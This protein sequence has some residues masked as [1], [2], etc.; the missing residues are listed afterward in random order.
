MTEPPTDLDQQRLAELTTAID[1][2]TNRL[3]AALESM[4]AADDRMRA[5]NERL[6]AAI[7]TTGRLRRPHWPM[8]YLTAGLGG[9][10]AALLVD[11]LLS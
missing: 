4:G 11:L 9:A 10:T 6:R 5:A 3:H 1:D 2:T 7:E 8:V